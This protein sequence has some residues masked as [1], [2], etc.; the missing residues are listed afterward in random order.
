MLKFNYHFCYLVQNLFFF[1]FNMT[2]SFVEEMQEPIGEFGGG[3]RKV[4]FAYEH[5]N[6]N[7]I[8]LYKMVL[9]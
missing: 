4:P 9:H 2:Q 8:S 3:E 6:N 7:K 5:N 1:F